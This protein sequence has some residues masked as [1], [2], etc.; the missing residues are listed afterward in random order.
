MHKFRLPKKKILAKLSSTYTFSTFIQRALGFV[1]LPIYT[2]TAYITKIEYGDLALVY[3]F[4]A[5]MTILYLYGMD[6][7]LLRFFFLGDH[8]RKQVDYIY[9][10]FP[11]CR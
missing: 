11:F 9:P 5:F 8:P 2:D 7:A 6:A 10:S 3:T 4:V 1:M